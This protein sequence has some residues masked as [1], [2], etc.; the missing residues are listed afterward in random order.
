MPLNVGRT[1]DPREFLRY[2]QETFQPRSYSMGGVQSNFTSQ[3]FPLDEKTGKYRLTLSSDVEGQGDLTVDV[4]PG[5]RIDDSHYS[6]MR[7]FTGKGSEWGQVFGPEMYWDRPNPNL[8]RG[9]VSA[10]MPETSFEKYMYGSFFM[11]TW[12]AKNPQSAFNKLTSEGSSQFGLAGG[13]M[14]ISPYYSPSTVESMARHVTMKFGPNVKDPSSALD[15][16]GSLMRPV[17]T[18]GIPTSIQGVTPGWFQQMAE[19]GLVPYKGDDEI[20]RWRPLNQGPVR[21][22]GGRYYMDMFGGPNK[23]KSQNVYLS[24]KE[25]LTDTGFFRRNKSGYLEPYTPEGITQKNQEGIRRLNIQ[26]GN[27]GPQSALVIRNA[28]STP[29]T[30]ASGTT[31]LLGGNPVERQ[32]LVGPFYGKQSYERFPNVDYKS[33]VGSGGDGWKFE[34]GIFGKGDDDKYYR[35]YDKGGKPKPLAGYTLNPGESAIIGLLKRRDPSSGDWVTKPITFTADQRTTTIKGLP[36][37]VAP[38]S[39]RPINK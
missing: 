24:E 15:Y 19:M 16:I 34:W 23:V 31:T 17:E 5:P 26:I 14:N 18:G 27:E 2:L 22:E 29:G 33:F 35:M 4:M 32:G 30:P 36:K 20:T 3:I 37:L 9:A 7:L 11:N 28:L 25:Q 38:P 1:Q 21:Q 12:D 8:P 13:L 6:I 10:N 39:I